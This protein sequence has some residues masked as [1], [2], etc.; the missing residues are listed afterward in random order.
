MISMNA[1]ISP[2]VMPPCF[3]VEEKPG[4]EML[5]VVFTGS[6]NKITSVQPFDFFKLTGLLNCHRIL[7]RDPKRCCYLNGI[8]D[9][10]FGGLVDRL[11]GEID[12]IGAKTVLFVG[13][14]AGGYASLVMGHL[15]Q[16]DYVHAFSPYTYINFL[17]LLMGKN[18]RDTIFRFPTIYFNVNFNIPRQYKKYL[19]TRP[20]LSQPGSKTRFFLH[21]CA[22]SSDRTRALHLKDCPGV[23]TFLYPC[24]NHNVT[25]GML[26]TG[27]LK[28][29][30]LPANLASPDKVY[31]KYYGSFDPDNAECADCKET[32]SVPSGV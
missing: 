15:L 5:V 29:M 25:F 32:L 4:A 14:S 12:R 7:I 16:P 28:E 1:K 6:A 18:Y 13:A 11:R 27:C 22:Q 19:D 8:D 2:E 24:K 31:A 3:L 30:L 20:H 23:E 26:R 17:R 10:G 21:A 9:T